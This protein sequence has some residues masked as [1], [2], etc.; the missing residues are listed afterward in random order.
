[1]KHC[2]LL[3]AALL[4]AACSTGANTTT[5]TTTTEDSQLTHTSGDPYAECRNDTVEQVTREANSARDDKGMHPL[6]C[7]TELADIAQA[8]ADDMCEKDYLSHTSKDGRTMVDR[9]RNAGFDFMTLG[10]N[11]AMGQPTAEK[12]HSSWM[13]SRMH[14]RNIL[15][16]EFSRLGVGYAPC[17][18]TP[19]WVQVFA[20]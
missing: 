18:G 2:I 1:M 8:H 9:A 3:F 10:E 19:Y 15:N 7:A 12:V 11:V 16:P 13:D 20:N 17:D 4:L 14:R 5:I 6:H